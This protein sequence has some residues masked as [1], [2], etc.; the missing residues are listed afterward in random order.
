MESL[1]KKNLLALA[2]FLMIIFVTGCTVRTYTVTRQR[3]DQ[4]LNSG[5]RGYVQGKSIPADPKRD[6]TKKEKVVEVEWHWPF[7]FE[8]LKKAPDQ[9]EPKEA[10]LDES[11]ADTVEVQDIVL[12]TQSAAQT[13]ESYTV[14]KD[15]TLQKISEKFYG[16]TK[17]WN[18]IYELNKD[19]LKSPDKLY[20][21]KTIKIP[22]K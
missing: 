5:N 17:R 18:E 19:V 7:K 4:D 9:K 22:A 13:Y 2:C 10:K 16:T 15:D 12:D 14:M 6:T 1:R 20:P 21:G 3:T 11:V 8:R